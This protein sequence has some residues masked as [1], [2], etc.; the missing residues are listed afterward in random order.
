MPYEKGSYSRELKEEHQQG[1][2]EEE[3][4]EFCSDCQR[5]ENEEL[6]R[7]LGFSSHEEYEDFVAEH[8]NNPDRD[9][10]E[11]IREASSKEHMMGKHQKHPSR[12]CSACIKKHGINNI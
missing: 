10:E 1:C 9:V 5:L 3:R 4:S 8:C 6:A 7:D 11:A 2:H 12:N